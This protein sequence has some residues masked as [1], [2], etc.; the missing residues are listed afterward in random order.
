MDV[1]PKPPICIEM[2]STTYPNVLKVLAVSTTVNPVVDTAL[3]AVKA[4]STTE[5]LPGCRCET[6]SN[7]KPVT[8]NIIMRKPSA[9][10]CTGVTERFLCVI[11]CFLRTHMKLKR[12]L[13]FILFLFKKAELLSSIFC[14]WSSSAAIESVISIGNAKENRFLMLS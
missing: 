8:N 3:T 13:S 1:I 14:T 5:R 2:Q 11:F 10:S 4:A 9:I 7:N 12:H 6:G